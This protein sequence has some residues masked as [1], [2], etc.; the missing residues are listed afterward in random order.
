MPAGTTGSPRAAR[1]GHDTHMYKLLFGLA[2]LLSGFASLA[3]QPPAVADSADT[4]LAQAFKTG[5]SNLQV[6][7]QGVV[8]RLLP[9]DNVGSRHQKFILRLAS[10]QTLLVAHNFDQAPRLEGLQAGD[11][12]EFL[13]EYEWSAKG[14][15]IHWTHRDPAGRHPAGWLR[16]K[17]RT[18]Q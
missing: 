3:L 2:L 14:G 13:G 18:Y 6:Q 12:L 11:R 9:D 15:V 7:G 8:E 5:R 16:Y 17:G 4:Q 1:R 10:G